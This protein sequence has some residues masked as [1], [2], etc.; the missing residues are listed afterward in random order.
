VKRAVWLVGAAVL[1]VTL[2]GCGGGAKQTTTTTTTTVPAATTV[3]AYFLTSDGKVK[4]ISREVAR[5]AALYDGAWSALIRGFASGEWIGLRSEVE[6]DPGDTL[7]RASDG[8]ITLTTTSPQSRGAL[9]QIVYTLTQFDTGA[10]V[11]VN[12]E[13]YTRADFEA[14]TPAI[15]VESPLPLQ[16][17]PSPIRVTGTANTFEATFQY[18]LRDAAGR[19]I[20]KHF[21]TATSGSGTRGTFDVSIPYPAGHAG[22]GRLVVYEN[23]AKD[24]S[25]INVSKIALRLT[26]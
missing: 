13:R 23:S 22:P 10:T 15:L 4:P 26:G 2:A 20:A 8:L 16:T 21:V 6:H 3:R 19:I 24:G 25:R 7:G 12:G 17:A 9:A 5:G 1:A 11:V 18:E 14:E